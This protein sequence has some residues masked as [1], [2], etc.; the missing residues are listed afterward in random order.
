MRILDQRVD[1]IGGR[2]HDLVAAA[3]RVAEAEPGLLRQRLRRRRDAA[4]LADDRDVAAKK[5]VGFA[6]KGGEAGGH[7]HPRVDDAD[8]IR[9][10]QR[11]ARLLAYAAQRLLQRTPR[12]AGLGEAAGP[13]D[14]ATNAR[15]R[16]FPDQRRNGIRPGGEDRDIGRRGKVADPRVARQAMHRGAARV[17]R[18]DRSRVAEFAQQPDRHAAEISGLVR[19]AD[20]RDRLRGEQCRDI[21]ERRGLRAF[22][23]RAIVS[24]HVLRRAGARVARSCAANVERTLP[25]RP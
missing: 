16:A 3:D 21:D 24:V 15:L 17:D 10:G 9:A 5:L 25:E 12:L 8:A 11:E 6:E 13:C 2:Q 4:A 19:G 7:R 22:D 18:P 23:H 14:P 20:H 1:E